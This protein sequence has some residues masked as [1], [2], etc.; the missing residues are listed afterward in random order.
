MFAEL[1]FPA[2]QPHIEAAIGLNVQVPQDY[3]PYHAGDPQLDFKEAAIMVL[4]T[5]C[6]DEGVLISLE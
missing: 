1:T 3:V 2:L 5:I 6:S 4:G